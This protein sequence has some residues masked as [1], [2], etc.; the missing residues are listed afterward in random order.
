[1]SRT[2]YV[3]GTARER[4]RVSGMMEPGVDLIVPC[5]IPAGRRWE[6][7]ILGHSFHTRVREASPK[8]KAVLLTWVKNE[9]QL[10]LTAGGEIMGDS[11]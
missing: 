10:R 6:R 5:S 9:L 8:E 7:I 1:M 3:V 4:D 11:R 2:A